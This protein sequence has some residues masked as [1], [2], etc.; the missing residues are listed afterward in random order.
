MWGAGWRV[1]IIT[2]GK[3]QEVGTDLYR[4]QS[5]L[6]YCPSKLP[7][8]AKDFISVPRGPSYR[9]LSMAPSIYM[10]IKDFHR[11]ELSK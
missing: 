7:C 8:P 4:K 10:L 9:I 1:W 2:P 3:E 6:L 11:G 5:G